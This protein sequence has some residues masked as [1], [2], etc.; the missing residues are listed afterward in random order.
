M[1]LK[2]H[3]EFQISL[4]ALVSAASQQRGDNWVIAGSSILYHHPASHTSYPIHRNASLL[5]DFG[6]ICA[7]YISL[8]KLPDPQYCTTTPRQLYP[9]HSN[10]S[11]YHDFSLKYQIATKQKGPKQW[12]KLA[13]SSILYHLPPHQPKPI[14]RNASLLPDLSLICIIS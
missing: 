3:V 8:K 4:I 11:S 6:F 10:A 9:I 7:S 5:P 12:V 1:K 14:H 13:R 2:S